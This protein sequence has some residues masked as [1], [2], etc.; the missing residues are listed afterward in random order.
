M[1]YSLRSTPGNGRRGVE[2]PHGNKRILTVYV[3]DDEH[4]EI[5][6]TASL[7]QK[8][9]SEFVKML[10]LGFEPKS[11]IDQEAVLALMKVNADLGRL[12]GLLKLGLVDQNLDRNQA[13]AL[14]NEISAAMRL[15]VDRAESLKN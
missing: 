9:V 15:V 12:G 6:R 3:T 13:N 1:V 10:A 14:L 7:A 4:E 5:K 11:K 2:M 8:S